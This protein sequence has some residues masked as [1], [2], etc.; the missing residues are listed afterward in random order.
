MSETAFG[1]IFGCVGQGC[2]PSLCM[3]SG[4]VSGHS[5]VTRLQTDRV[6]VPTEHESWRSAGRVGSERKSHMYVQNLCISLYASRQI[7]MLCMLMLTD[8]LGSCPIRTKW[9]L[10]FW[11][12]ASGDGK[13]CSFR[14]GNESPTSIWFREWVVCARRWESLTLD[15]RRGSVRMGYPAIRWAKDV[16]K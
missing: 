11:I 6:Y 1:C 12:W 4:Q 10:A 8:M 15:C 2:I 3:W 16:K 5:S 14:H 9:A 13:R 7:T